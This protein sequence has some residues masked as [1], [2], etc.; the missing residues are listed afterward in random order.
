MTGGREHQGS[1]CRGVGVVLLE[2]FDP[3]SGSG[4]GLLAES[5][6]AE[7]VRPIARLKT[8]AAGARA[9]KILG[10]V[11]A[12]YDSAPATANAARRPVLYFRAARRRVVHEQ[13]SSLNWKSARLAG[14]VLTTRLSAKRGEVREM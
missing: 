5:S 6:N 4:R 11:N 7:D 2:P 10:R 14:R 1:S 13:L 9:R 12:V 8:L 3:S